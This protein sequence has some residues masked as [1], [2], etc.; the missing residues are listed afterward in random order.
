VTDAAFD[1]AVLVVLQH[2]GGYVNDPM[3]SGGETNFGI[4]KRSYPKLDIRHL[5]PEA[6]IQI[7]RRDWW[8][9][10]R[11][12]TLP[13]PIGAKMLDLAVNMGITHATR[14]LQQGLNDI[15]QD[16]LEDGDLGPQTRRACSG[17]DPAELLHALREAAADYYRGLAEG[18]P[19]L[20]KFLKGWLRRAAA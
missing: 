8:D 1:G 15:G 19:A 2:E 11:L 5:T 13:D 12:G 10:Y 4:S 14:C 20:R 17:A 3:D 16:V 6:A 18:H 9:R 7:Y